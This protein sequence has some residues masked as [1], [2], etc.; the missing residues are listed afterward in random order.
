MARLVHQSSIDFPG[1]TDLSIPLSRP[2]TPTVEDKQLASEDVPQLPAPYDQGRPGHDFHQ[3]HLHNSNKQGN[4]PEKRDSVPAEYRLSSSEEDVLP[5][6][7]LHLRDRK[8]VVHLEDRVAGGAD[9]TDKDVEK[10]AVSGSSF[11]PTQSPAG[12]KQED[13]NIVDWDGP[14]DPANP[15]NWNTSKETTT[16]ALASVITFIT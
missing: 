9:G 14:D 2:R 5:K 3:I 7:A 8:R 15:T 1:H 10:E 6:R 16:I 13:A 12:E 11:S 4:D